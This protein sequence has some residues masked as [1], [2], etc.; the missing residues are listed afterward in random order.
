[1]RNQA[2][3]RTFTVTVSPST[4]TAPDVTARTSSGY[5]VPAL[6]QVKRASGA[7]TP[8]RASTIRQFTPS[9]LLSS[10]HWAGSRPGT[11]FAVHRL[12]DVISGVSAAKRMTTIRWVAGFSGAIQLLIRHHLVPVL[13]SKSLSAP[14][15][16]GFPSAY[17]SGVANWPGSNA[18]TPLPCVNARFRRTPSAQ[19]NANSE[20]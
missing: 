6:Y 1:M 13:L 16:E 11:S 2:P 20:S 5:A 19:Y 17:V 4:P 14:S 3:A 7:D 8:E 12:Y 18:P 15:V 9:G 10:V